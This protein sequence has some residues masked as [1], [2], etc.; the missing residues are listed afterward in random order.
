M[1]KQRNI[2]IIC[3]LNHAH[4]S[5]HVDVDECADGTHDCSPITQTCI[6]TIGSFTCEC[7]SGYELDGDGT[8]CNGMYKHLVLFWLY[9]IKYKL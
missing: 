8:T 1:F 3:V 2:I 6:N 7:S 9:H 5:I 4:I